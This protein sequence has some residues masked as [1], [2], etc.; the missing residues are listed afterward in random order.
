MEDESVL[1]SVSCIL[2][3]N[4]NETQI[5]IMIDII[6]NSGLIEEFTKY[7]CDHDCQDIYLTVHEFCGKYP[8]KFVLMNEKYQYNTIII[9]D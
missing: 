9:N 1:N 4:I 8:D 7:Y 3:S 6:K 5:K 2:A